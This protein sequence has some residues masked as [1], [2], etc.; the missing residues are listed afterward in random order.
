MHRR[1]DGICCYQCGWVLAS[2][3]LEDTTQPY[4]QHDIFFM[5]L[6]FTTHYFL[7]INTAM[8]S[9]AVENDLTCSICLD[10]FDC[11]TT[12]SCGH[13]F[14]LQCLEDACK[15]AKLFTC[16]HCRA[17]YEQLPQLSKNVVLASLVET[18][19]VQAAAALANGD[20]KSPSVVD[21][22]TIESL[23]K[24]GECRWCGKHGKPV[25]MFCTLDH[26]LICTA[27]TVEGEHRSHNVIT[28]E[29]EKE[30]RKESLK[31]DMNS[32]TKKEKEAASQ[33]YVLRENYRVVQESTK[34]NKAKI[35]SK[36]TW[37]RKLLDE[38]ERAA[39]KQLEDNGAL[40]LCKIQNNIN[41]FERELQAL[42]QSKQKLKELLFVEDPIDFL[43]NSFHNEIRMYIDQKSETLLPPAP[44]QQDNVTFRSLED[45]INKR[46]RS[47]LTT[48]YG[49]S[50]TLN[51]NTAHSNLKLSADLRT[52]KRVIHSQRYA[53]HPSRFDCWLQA[54]CSQAFSSGR[55]YLEVDVGGS[56]FF[57][58]GVACETIPRKGHWQDNA[59]GGS[60]SSWVVGRRGVNY[61]AAHGDIFYKIEVRSHLRRVGVYLEWESG[62][63]SFY[64]TDTMDRL[65]LFSHKF[66]QPLHPGLYVGAGQVTIHGLP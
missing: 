60:K 14:C 59:L 15:S 32:V 12:L 34:N 28:L 39:L 66:V 38:E 42:Q 26:A 58:V 53:A 65:H 36:Y 21:S 17:P 45:V 27:C 48:G 2:D 64:N 8:A 3:Q 52:A 23:G 25:Q 55:H 46:L 43:Q 37:Q 35:S 29:R 49:R 13:S 44:M 54:L 24:D 63:L 51:S 18:L 30:A 1:I 41:S 40:L 19:S 7:C 5:S 31:E 56:D 20:D 62:L 57:F 4:I 47:F 61:I 50:P 6:P 16:P 11:P 9:A 10:L 22:G 33:L